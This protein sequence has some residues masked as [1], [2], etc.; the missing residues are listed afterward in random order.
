MLAHHST[1]I[2]YT[3][4]VGALQ[5]LTLTRPELAYAVQQ[6]YVFMHAPTDTHFQ[7]IKRIVRYI[8]GTSSYGLQLHRDSSHDLVAYPDMD[9]ACCPDTGKST[10]G[11]GE[12][13]GSNLVSWSSK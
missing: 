9:W 12:F 5:Y 8:R 11:F 1:T 13:L 6:V 3:G 4:V 10:S 2:S 7:L